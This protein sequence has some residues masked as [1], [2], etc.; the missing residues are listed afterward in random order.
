MTILQ[1]TTNAVLPIFLLILCGFL[2]RAAGIL[3]REDVGRIN[4]LNFNVFIPV[5]V[6]YNIHN[7]KLSTAFRPAFIAYAVLGL[8]AEAGLAWVFTYFFVKK[9]DQKGVV[10]QG[11]FRT[12]VTLI[13]VQLLENLIPGADLGPIS[14]LSACTT[15]TINTV[16]VIA[17]ETY[18]GG[19]TGARHLLLSIL[20]LLL[21]LLHLLLSFLLGLLQILLSLFSLFLC[22]CKTVGQGSEC[23][24]IFAMRFR[25]ASLTYI[26]IYSIH[27][28][29]HLLENI[30]S[31][32]KPFKVFPGGSEKCL[33]PVIKTTGSV[34]VCCHVCMV[35]V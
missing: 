29:S 5:L 1:N 21:S 32:R 3:K 34:C 9:R 17:L 8:L 33:R 7:S 10:I 25:Q 12:N 15:V 19:K 14:L 22:S 23:L 27:L 4:K 31:L 35:Q 16:S 26:C 28:L 11:L 6:A 13:G 30:S 2:A 18:S 24:H 20:H